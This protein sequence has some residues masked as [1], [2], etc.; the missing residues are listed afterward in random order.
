MKLDLVIHGNSNHTGMGIHT[1]NLIKE[2][3]KSRTVAFVPIQPLQYQNID[4]VIQKA[5]DMRCHITGKEPAIMNYHAEWMVKFCG[6]P[7]IGFA[8]FETDKIPDLEL[9]YYLTLD[10]IL[11]PSKWAKDVLV[12]NLSRLNVVGQAEKQAWTYEIYV[13]PEGY[14]PE[15][16]C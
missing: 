8:I 4:E 9:A 1:Y 6:H 14:D 15:I 10:K 2:L 7:R 11:V 5:L 13:V 3:S 12:K 16:F